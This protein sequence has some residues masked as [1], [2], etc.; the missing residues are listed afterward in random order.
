MST[1]IIQVTWEIVCTLPA[2]KHKDQYVAHFT[3]CKLHIWVN[4]NAFMALLFGTP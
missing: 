4:N 1:E 2:Q 3:L